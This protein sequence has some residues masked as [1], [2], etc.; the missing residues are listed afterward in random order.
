MLMAPCCFAQQV[1]VYSSDAAQEAKADIRRRLAAGET[2]QQILDAYVAK[3]AKH[4][5][6]LWFIYTA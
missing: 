5:L 1:S 2:Q 4:I 6:G 3:Y